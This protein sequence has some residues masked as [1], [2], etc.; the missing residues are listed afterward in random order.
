MTDF[1]KEELEFIKD[2]SNRSY[3]NNTMKS[4]S[5]DSEQIRFRDFKN[6]LKSLAEKLKIQFNSDFGEFISG[7]SSGNPIKFGGTK[8]NRIWSGIFKGAENKQYA[9]QISFVVDAES[10]ALDIGFFFGRAASRGKSADMNRLLFLGK[11]LS[12]TIRSNIHLKKQYEEL[13]DFGFKPISDSKEISS[14][15]WL[16]II[17][18][19]PQNSQLV[20]KLK[21]NEEGI[22]ETSTIVLYVK[23]LL[24]LMAIIPTEGSDKSEIKQS[25]LTPEQRA[26]QAERRALIGL[27]GEKFIFGKEQERL[28]ELNINHKFYLEHVS[29]ISDIFGYDIKSCDDNKNEIFIEVKTTTRK[30][31]YYL[32]N[33]FFLSDLEYNFYQNNKSKYKLI[34][35][36][37][38]DGIPEFEEVNLN[39]VHLHI[40]SYRVE[41]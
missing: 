37:D 26:K 9:A 22:I 31:Q 20:Y 13:I 27:K 8:L 19:T 16:N 23:M 21:I 5:T 15:D 6:N 3:R 33:Q 25:Y 39:D 17:T 36:Y 35:V 14:E 40:D 10:N 1:R 11:T 34:R 32:A 24:F 7:A 2:L 12:Q 29:L 38:I 30:K 41:I 18:Q 4:N 28:I